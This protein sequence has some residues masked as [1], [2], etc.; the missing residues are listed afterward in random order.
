MKKSAAIA[1]LFFLLSGVQRSFA[2]APRKP[3]LESIGSKV[4]CLCGGCD[5]TLGDCPHLPSQCA[6]RAEETAL[7]LKEIREGKSEAAILHDLADRYGVRVL[8]APP[9][10]GFNLAAW[11]LPGFALIVGLVVVVLLVRRFRRRSSPGKPETAA[12]DPSIMAAVEEELNRVAP[13]KD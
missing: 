13:L 4:Y 7:I 6:S 3:T 12:V 11:T 8:A 1:I 10:K 9:A 2:G 5:T